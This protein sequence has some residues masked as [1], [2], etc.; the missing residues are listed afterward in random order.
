MFYIQMGYP[1]VLQSNSDSYKRIGEVFASLFHGDEEAFFVFWQDIPIR[2]RYREDLEYNFSS[3]LAMLQLLKESPEGRTQFILVNEILSLKI[4]LVWQAELL[5]LDMK[6]EANFHTYDEYSEI[7]NRK[8]A[9]EM[10]K[11]KFL[12]EWHT[13]IHQLVL[14]FHAGKVCID[15]GLEKSNLELLHNLDRQLEGYGWMYTESI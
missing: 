1:G 3:I 9:F 13:L 15:G 6:V 12:A 14:S 10:D 8:N 7:L 4:N 5:H 11:N 2:F